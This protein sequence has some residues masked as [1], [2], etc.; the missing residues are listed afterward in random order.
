MKFRFMTLAASL[1]LYAASAQAADIKGR[2]SEIPDAVWKNMQGKSWHT[3]LPCPPRKDL[4]YLV[5]PFRD[6][7]GKTQ[8]GE[9]IVA[10]NQADNVGT[11][12]LSIL[13]PCGN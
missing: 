4:R 1:L 8:L 13:P 10:K 12:G 6:F 7:T 3:N 5:V 2:A 11:T 9:L